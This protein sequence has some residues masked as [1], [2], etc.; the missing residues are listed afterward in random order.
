M[1]RFISFLKKCKKGFTL[2]ECVCAIA[3]VGLLSAIIL[4]LTA[5]AIRSMRVSDAIRTK[6][7]EASSRN[8]TIKTD[9]KA[10]KLDD[11]KK[12]A[13]SEYTTYRTMYV[14][15]SYSTAGLND[16]RAE[17]AFVFTESNTKDKDLGVSVTYYDLKYGK[18]TED[19]K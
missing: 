2:M 19:A 18:E 10:A 1:K 4:P 17:S 15:I 6:A 11:K 14:T 3:V 16:M 5:S 12:D 7:A 8:A 13:L 9:T